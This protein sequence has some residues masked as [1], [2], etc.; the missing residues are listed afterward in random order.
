MRWLYFLFAK[1]RMQW[2]S[3]NENIVISKY[4]GMLHVGKIT[5]WKII[6][7]DKYTLD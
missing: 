2:V 3:C 5:A 1:P 4:S 6:L 7:Q